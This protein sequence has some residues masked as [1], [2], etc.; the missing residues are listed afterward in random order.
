MGHLISF[1]SGTGKKI[2]TEDR[3]VADEL[4]KIGLKVGSENE[5]LRNLLIEIGRGIGG[6]DDLKESFAK[7]TDPLDPALRA[8]QRETSDHVNLRLTPRELRTSHEALRSEF[9]EL[10]KKLAAKGIE[11]EGAQG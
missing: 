5:A 6:L 4:A 2:H 9:K 3:P 11:C 1:F 7:L 10:G 8:P